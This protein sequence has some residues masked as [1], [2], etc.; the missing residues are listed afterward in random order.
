MTEAA[1]QYGKHLGIAFQLKDDLLD[2]EASAE[3]LGKPAG[4]L[5]ID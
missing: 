1:F 2:F 4:K 5:F 3:L